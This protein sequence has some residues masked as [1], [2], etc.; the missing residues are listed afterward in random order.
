[1]PLR[2]AFLWRFRSGFS[3]AP[4]LFTAH[5]KPSGRAGR[6]AGPRAFLGCFA[7]VVVLGGGARFAS[8]QPA[9]LK[10]AALE[11]H[12][13]YFNGMENEPIVNAVPNA[14]ATVWLE[15]NIP[16]FECSDAGVEE[17]Y[18]FRWWAMRK[19]LR[20]LPDGRFVFTEFITKARPISSALGHQLY[21]G[22]W[23]RDPRFDNDYILYWLRGNE[24]GPQKDLHNYSSWL[25]DAVYNRALASGDFA[26]ATSLLHDL[27]RDFEKWDEE[28]LLPSG[29][30][31]QYDV[32]DAMEESIS[33]SRKKKNIRPTINSY[34]FGNAQAIAALARMAAQPTLA[35]QYETKA[36]A[37]RQRIL[38]T[39]WD[40]EAKF[41]EVREEDGSFAQA[42]E[43]LGYIPW[44]FE[45]PPPSSGYEAAWA[46]FSDPAGF[47]APFGLTTAERRHPQ[48]RSHGV[49][50]CEWDGAVWPFAT[51]QTLVALAN[52]LRDYPQ[53]VVTNRDYY[54]AFL[55]YIHS[56]HYDGLPYIGEYLDEKT[57]QWLKGRNERSRWYNHSTF[58]DLLITG[59]VGLRPR[60]DGLV[61]IQPLLP[62][63]AWE[64]FCLDAVPYHG[65][66]LTIIWDVDGQHYKRG[67]GLTVL[68]DGS[69]F[70]HAARLEPVSGQLPVSQ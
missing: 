21:E 1:M 14:A 13:A 18:Y 2:E 68:C 39:L 11:R 52:V 40:P 45:L 5:L 20:Q 46:Q 60:A 63:G 49:G 69:P 54:N 7:V 61:Q 31:W 19:Q 8:A 55:T 51:S 6:A 3:R 36:A 29:L 32:R 57:G 62:A 22:R 10:T 9:V 59:L 15:R 4:A 30:Y 47:S 42:R 43:E 58:S 33:G 26:F 34:M 53:Q 35:A 48:F 23:L 24:G 66:S 50:G 16:W 44:Y 56:Q 38:A 12:V 65:H 37:L 27:V 67:A 41:F 70:I 64:W 25:A 17:M 28:K